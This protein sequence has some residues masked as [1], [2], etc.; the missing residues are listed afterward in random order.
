MTTKTEILNELFIKSW[1]WDTVPNFDEPEENSI[2]AMVLTLYDHEK[3]VMLASYPWRRAIK[4]VTV[5]CVPS[6][7]D[8]RYE[9]QALLP[10]DFIKEYGFWADNKRGIKLFDGCTVTGNLLLSKRSKLTLGYIADV[11]EEDFDIWTSEYFVAF[12][13]AELARVGGQSIDREKA[14]K[15]DEAIAFVRAKNRDYEMTEKEVN[16]SLHQFCEWY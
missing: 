3:E 1:E 13:A 5:E 2:E 8:G 15:E 6:T 14:L 10:E 7:L 9:Y 4:Y 11:P 12:L 16:P